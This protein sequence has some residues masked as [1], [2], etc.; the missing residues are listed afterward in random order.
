MF[1]RA[2]KPKAAAMTD[3]EAP[4]QDWDVATKLIRGGID[5]T[6]YGET[7]E[8]MFLTQSFV[9]DSAEA[10]NARF[11]GDEPGFVY[12]R[13]A[14]PTCKMF[15]D[16]LALL[17]GAEACRSTGSRPSF[18]YAAGSTWAGVTASRQFRSRSPSVYSGWTR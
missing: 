5:R 10:A 4:H 2:R 14:N 18:R 8:A 15:E 9:Y 13:Y 11:A 3:K 7:A 6:A 12:S 17:E 16:R 1:M